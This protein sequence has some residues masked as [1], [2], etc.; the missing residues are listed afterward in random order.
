MNEFKNRKGRLLTASS[1]ALAAIL[2][3]GASTGLAQS[4]NVTTPDGGGDV[5]GGDYSG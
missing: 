1:L 2:T 3:M 4:S 5:V